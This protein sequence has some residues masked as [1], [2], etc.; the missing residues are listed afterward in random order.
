MSDPHPLPP[1]SRRRFVGTAAALGAGVVL[2]RSL[3]AAAQPPAPFAAGL[4]P[5]QPA[6][7][8]VRAY[9]LTIG[10]TELRIDGRRARATTINGTVPGPVLRFREGDRAVI[11]VRNTLREDTSIHWHGI[12]LP[13]EMDGVPGLSFPGIGP[14]ETFEYRFDVRQAG[15]YWYHSHSGL[16]EQL[17]HYGSL[18][19]EPADAAPR[20]HD[21]EHVVVLSDWT[22]ENPHRV[23]SRLK[24]QP[25]AYNFQR[26]T[27]SDFFRDASRDGLR[28]TVRDRLMWAGMRMNPT[29]LADV[30]GATYSYLING[31]V[32]ETPWTG[33]FAPGERVLVRFINAAAS[34]L[35]DLRL[36]GVP[37][38]V[39]Q[40]SGQPV[41]P[42]ETDELRIAPAE[43]YDVLVQL[44]D[45]R[46]YPIYAE[47][48]D[49]SGFTAGMLAPRAG[50][51]AALPPR[52]RRAVLAMAD[53]GMDHGAMAGIDH[54]AMDHA[55]MGHVM[56]APAPKPAAATT[57]DA[58]A[59][60]DMSAMAP[61]S[62]LRE[63]G[64][65]PPETPHA[66]GSHGVGNAMIP[67]STKSRLAEPGVGLGNDGRRV[68][69]YAALR[70]PA[71]WPDFRAPTR[72]I[73]VH[74][75]GNMER[76][77]WAIGDQPHDHA[78]PIELMHGERVRLTMVND[79][80]MNHP[81]HLHGM[82]MEL[83]NGQGDRSP[84]IHT[85]NVKPA[86]RVSLLIT[87]DAVGRWAFHC[88]LLY[89]ME[90]G[91]F[92]EVRVVAADAH[93]GHGDAR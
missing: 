42:V 36:P 52:R 47:T 40:V 28:A 72:E 74:L 30:T 86:E 9:D 83:E 69:T 24:K 32:A 93:R 85:I 4:T 70:A 19:I 49:R 39:L 18:V 55:A 77:T 17:G 10:E 48:I 20:R 78:A 27:V 41:E 53:M 25:D 66:A 16:Q 89:H 80:M 8:G 23:L 22:F 91:M 57:A 88:H 81:M 67:M 26:R 29:D 35:F 62:T 2:P 6:P 11:R 5:L 34:T 90:V 3:E 56:P 73:E 59:G 1:L 21:R 54:S 63:P 33:Q 76:F 82:W 75:T 50:M 46:A 92:R 14:G 13:P 15:T 58:H 65:I 31:C 61:A 51:T 87:A 37:M 68:L 38:T 84:R 43:T 64:T 71:P 44:P 12:L 45:D 79:T 60:H 7:S